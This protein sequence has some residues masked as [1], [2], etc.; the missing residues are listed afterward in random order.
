MSYI[1]IQNIEP[2]SLCIHTVHNSLLIQLKNKYNF[3]AKTTCLCLS[4]IV[5]RYMLTATQ[6]FV[7]QSLFDWNYYTEEVRFEALS[8]PSK[9][10]YNYVYK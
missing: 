5:V 9:K 6:R 4:C 3:A 2:V 7:P 10:R 8:F 1:L